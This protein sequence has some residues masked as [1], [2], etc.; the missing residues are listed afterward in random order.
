ME[1]LAWPALGESRAPARPAVPR[2]E[3]RPALLRSIAQRLLRCVILR[4]GPLVGGAG[5]GHAL[6]HV[7][8]LGE[9]RGADGS[10]ITNCMRHRVTAV[11]ECGSPGAR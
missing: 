10:T 2:C 5:S 4:V 1:H 7:W 3:G 8:L 6:S 9:S 11:S